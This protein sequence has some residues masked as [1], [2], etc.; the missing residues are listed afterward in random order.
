MQGLKYTVDIVFCIDATGSMGHL[1]NEVKT[2]AL[3]FEEDLTK[4]MNE[5]EKQID[6][7][8]VKVAL[9]HEY[10]KEITVE[11][12]ENKKDGRNFEI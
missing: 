1:I 5:K 6:T 12:G 3:K 9:L 10:S 2:G 4:L 8:R 11:M 7:L